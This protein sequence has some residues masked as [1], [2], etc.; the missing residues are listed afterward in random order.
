MRS[1]A[2]VLRHQAGEKPAQPGALG[3]VV[4]A[5]RTGPAVA[6]PG[7]TLPDGFG[8]ALDGKPNVRQVCV[9]K[10]NQQFVLLQHSMGHGDFFLKKNSLF[11]HV[12]DGVFALGMLKP[13]KIRPE[14]SETHLRHICTHTFAI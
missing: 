12:R 2:A 5:D 14:G 6:P 1:L 10:T 4:E 13:K 8:G 9:P 11:W 3:R 7:A